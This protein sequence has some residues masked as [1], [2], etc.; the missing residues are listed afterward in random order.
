LKVLVDV[1][2]P[3]KAFTRHFIQHHYLLK[4]AESGQLIISTI[5]WV[6]GSLGYAAMPVTAPPA[7]H[8]LACAKL[9]E[10]TAL[11]ANAATAMSLSTIK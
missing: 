4:P 7:C 2:W 11:P 10:R 3:E 1:A 9:P 8:F 5:P 6:L